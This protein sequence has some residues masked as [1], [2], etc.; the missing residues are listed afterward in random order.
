MLKKLGVRDTVRMPSGQLIKIKAALAEG[1]FAIVFKA[2]NA[3]HTPF[4]L[5]RLVHSNVAD[6]RARAVAE[7][8]LMRRANAASPEHTARLVESVVDDVHGLAYLLVEFATDGSLKDRLDAAPV[9]RLAFGELAPWFVHVAIALSDLHALEPPIVH[10][11]VKLENVLLFDGGRRAKLCDFGSAR[12]GRSTPRSARE[13]ADAEDDIA[14]HTTPAYRAPE[15]VDLY[16]AQELGPMVDCW[17]F[18]VAL[19]L[20]LY[21]RHAFGGG[22]GGLSSLSDSLEF[23][24]VPG[25]PK[26]APMLC[27]MM[28][29]KSPKQRATMRAM[30]ATLAPLARMDLPKR[31]ASSAAR[32]APPPAPAPRRARDSDES[33]SDDDDDVQPTA[34]PA[35]AVQP[36]AVAAASTSATSDLVEQTWRLGAASLCFFQVDLVALG[37]I[38]ASAAFLK[39]LHELLFT[40]HRSMAA[41]CLAPRGVAFFRAFRDGWLRALAMDA[42]AAQFL[43]D[44]AHLLAQ[45]AV[46]LNRYAVLDGNFALAHDAPPAAVLDGACAQLALQLCSSCMLVLGPL[47]AAADSLNEAQRACAASAAAL[48]TEASNAFVLASHVLS[49]NGSPECV[50]L[51]GGEYVLVFARIQRLFAWAATRRLPVE[52]FALPPTPPVFNGQF[53]VPLPLPLRRPLN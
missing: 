11:D 27:R 42:L 44:Y 7:I 8:D 22:E 40:G 14:Q 13:I 34:A 30:L 21:G 41:E 36:A 23:P 17:A 2:S 47:V 26:Q 25:V 35:R 48:V 9:G 28:L 3:S 24:D 19:F 49:R 38:E 16:S 29:V 12:A 50:A 51:A 6:R 46:L 43:A 32:S 5:K 39:R 4:A 37:T 18:G 52:L 1:G 53:V 45:K 20:A 33:E 10:R 15:Q 31:H